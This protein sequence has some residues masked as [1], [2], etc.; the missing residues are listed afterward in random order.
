MSHTLFLLFNHRFTDLQ[1]EDARK[2]LGVDHIVELPHDLQ[3]IWSSL[4]P[5]EPEL[6]PVLGPIR[7]WLTSAAEPGDFV[8][9]QG[10][11]G[12]CYLMVRFCLEHGLIP[13]YSTTERHAQEEA[14][15]DGSIRLM[16]TFQH[17]I[18]RRY[19]R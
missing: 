16:H 6:A 7:S 4:P 11:F 18:F 17:R 9:I 14:Q 10:D 8:L 1:R 19:G 12:A 13:I 5:D 15:P 3:A 2:S